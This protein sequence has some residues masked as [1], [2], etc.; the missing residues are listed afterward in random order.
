MKISKAIEIVGNLANWHLNSMG[1]NPKVLPKV[2]YS[3]EEMIKANRIVENYDKRRMANK[4]GGKTM[5]VT[6]DDR[7]IAAQYV[8]M[9][10]TPDYCNEAEPKSGINGNLV[11]VICSV[12]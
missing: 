5:H 4:S 11:F 8:A 10:F 2:D 3:L 7:L 1:I 9:N 12:E 6:L